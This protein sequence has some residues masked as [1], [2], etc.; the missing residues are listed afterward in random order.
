MLSTV[1]KPGRHDKGWPRFS[2]VV[3]AA[4]SDQSHRL[5]VRVQGG[6]DSHDARGSDWEGVQYRPLKL[7]PPAA[8]HG[9][10]RGQRF[11]Q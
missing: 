11:Q 10:S 7:Q 4:S 9:T 3:T 1:I 2:L 5:Y 6:V 8:V